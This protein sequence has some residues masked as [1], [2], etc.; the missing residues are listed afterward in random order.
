MLAPQTFPTEKDADSW[1]R[2]KRLEIERGEHIDP[3]LGRVTLSEYVDL[4]KKSSA[5][6]ELRPSTKNRDLDYVRNYLLPRLGK[7][8]LEDLDFQTIDRWIVDLKDHGGRRS[9]PLGNETVAKSISALQQDSRLGDPVRPH[10]VQSLQVR[11]ATQ[12]PSRSS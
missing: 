6:A 3:K 8:A 4:W 10:L 1:L 9:G 5:F 2:Q 12:S 11:K 7:V